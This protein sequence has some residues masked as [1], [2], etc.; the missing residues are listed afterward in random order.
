MDALEG[1][2]VH[3]FDQTPENPPL[4][5]VPQICSMFSNSEIDVIIGLGGGSPMDTAKAVAVLLM[6]PQLDAQE[7]YDPTKYDTAKNSSAF[8]QLQVPVAR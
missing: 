6:N 3:I 5:L 7:L 8:L 1:R 2:H 4:E